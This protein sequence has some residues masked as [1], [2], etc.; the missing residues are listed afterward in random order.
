MKQID[1]LQHLRT[2]FIDLAFGILPWFG[3]VW[4]GLDWFI[5]ILFLVLFRSRNIIGKTGCDARCRRHDFEID[6]MKKE[7]LKKC[8]NPI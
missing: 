4:I 1:L 6:E 2:D 8:Q 7:E 3:L 5:I